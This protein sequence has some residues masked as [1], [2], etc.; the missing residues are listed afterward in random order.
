MRCACASWRSP[1]S[2]TAAP[3]AA[4]ARVPVVEPPELDAQQ[5]RLQ[6]VQ[7]RVEAFDLGH[8]PG[9]PA[10]AAQAAQ[11]ARERLVVG[12]DRAAVAD[13]AEV[14]RRIERERRCARER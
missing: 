6:L 10:I 12:R 13:R 3:I 1:R 11:L 7:A 5:R 2:A 8:A 14:L 9:A 4:A